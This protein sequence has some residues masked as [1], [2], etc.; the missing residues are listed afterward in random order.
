MFVV[1]TIYALWV[2]RQ[3]DWIACG[4]GAHGR[5]LK[6]GS[7]EQVHR[8]YKKHRTI[9]PVQSCREEGQAC[10]PNGRSSCVRHCPEG[11]YFLE[12]T[13]GSAGMAGGLQLATG[14]FCISGRG[15]GGD[16]GH[17][18]GSPLLSFGTVGS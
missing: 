4:G 1:E 13:D 17:R 6:E 18:K 8:I 2:C 5:R 3:Q 12:G 11:F 14:M 9:R 7:G 10:R 16:V 15:G